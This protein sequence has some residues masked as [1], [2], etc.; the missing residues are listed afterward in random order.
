MF[1]MIERSI[2]APT[3]GRY[4]VA[5]PSSLSGLPLIVG[6]HGYA[7]SAET[8]M[9]RLIEMDGSD[10]WVVVSVQGLHRFYRRSSDE[11]VAS[12]MTRQDRSHAIADN[13]SYVRSVI[14]SVSAEWLTGSNLVFSGFSQGV[15]MAFRAAASSTRPVSA[16]IACGG[17]VPPEL[18]ITSL[19]KIQTALIGRGSRDEW[20]TAEKLEADRQRLAR[21]GISVETV[22]VDG[23]H[24]WTHEFSQ[25]ASDFLKPWS[26]S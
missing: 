14:D 20:Y 26:G 2:L 6:F 12:W 21:A 7:E 10:R 13:H 9:R 11:V 16:V 25:A 23:A 17:D 3:H 22:T 1:F 5:A 4:L 24:D 8:Q 19:S 15:A 18:D